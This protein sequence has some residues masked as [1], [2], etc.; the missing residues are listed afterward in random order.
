VAV[1]LGWHA[2]GGPPD[3]A[4]AGAQMSRTTA[5]LDSAVLVFREGL[6]TILVL[7]AVTASFLGGNRV[8][9][10]PVAVGGV[11][12]RASCWR[13]S[14]SGS[15]SPPPSASSRSACTSGCRTAGC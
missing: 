1:V 9:R 13:A 15:C 6:E 2:S 7:A 12:A 10:R 11:L 4:A 3:P 8:Y 14:C 5:A